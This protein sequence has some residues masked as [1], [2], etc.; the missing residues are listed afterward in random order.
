MCNFFI[1]LLYYFVQHQYQYLLCRGVFFCVQFFFCIYIFSLL[2]AYEWYKKT[3]TTSKTY[4]FTFHRQSAFQIHEFVIMYVN[5]DKYNKNAFDGGVTECYNITDIQAKATTNGKFFCFST[6][7][8]FGHHQ[9]CGSWNV[10]VCAL[11]HG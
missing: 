8:I 10:C 9:C 11:W 6:Y 7:N 1:P 5:R 2:F 3:T 4:L